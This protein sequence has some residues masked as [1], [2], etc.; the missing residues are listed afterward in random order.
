MAKINSLRSYLQ[1]LDEAGQLARVKTPVSLVHE[2][3]DV[4]ASLA[5]RGGGGVIFEHPNGSDWPIFTN[6]IVNQNEAALALGCSV[7][8]VSDHMGF[9]IE[10]AN[11][12]APRSTETALW[13]QNVMQ[14]PE[15]DLHKLPIPT[16]GAHDGGPFITGGVTVSRDPLSGRGN[17]SYNRMQ[18]L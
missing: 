11:G 9:A 12:I 5:R 8:E 2:L 4:A 17:L 6:A 13:K 15:I 3:A 10:P 18:V 1:V 16:H 7:S 14:G